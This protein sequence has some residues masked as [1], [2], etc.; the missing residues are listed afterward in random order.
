MI[1]DLRLAAFAALLIVGEAFGFACG[2]IAVAWPWVAAIAIVL[3]LAAFGWEVHGTL[4]LFMFLFGL[5]SAARIE[6]RRVEVT[7]VWCAAMGHVRRQ[8]DLRVEGEP[9][10]RYGAKGR[11]CVSFLSHLG[12]VPIK[13]VM[14][15]KKRP[16]RLPADGE[17]WRCSGALSH[18]TEQ[19]C[20]FGRRTYWI[21]EKGT[22]FPVAPPSAIKRTLKTLSNACA[23]RMGIGLGWCPEIYAANRAML[24]GRR[25]ELPSSCRRNFV[26]AGTVH[27]FAVSGLHVMFVALLLMR[28]LA[29]M[30]VPFHVCGLAASPFLVGYVLLTGCRPSAVRAAMMACIYLCAPAVGRKSDLLAAW[31]LTALAI[32][33]S[34]PSRLFDVGCTLSFAVM[35]G[36]VVWLRWIRPYLPGCVKNG[37]R[38]GI[39]ISFAAWVSG[40]PI[41]AHEFCMFT[42]AGM[43]ANVAVLPL[44][45]L[46]VAFGMVG[47]SVGFILPA[48][49]VLFNNL[50]AVSTF[51]MMK[52]S[53]IVAAV[54]F[55]S[56]QVEPWPWGG[57][58][59]WYAGISILVVL[60]VRVASR[61]AWWS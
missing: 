32:Y 9:Q 57:C 28:L 29:F 49:A 21:T 31:S 50:A 24:L 14:L 1:T 7:D 56:I 6:A 33:G 11:W 8:V 27:V 37:W 17:T 52:I 15:R 55:A 48:A 34:N 2:P 10:V 38:E 41:V 19:T 18:Q 36:I 39:G 30:Q 40:A 25:A 23:A 45:A 47:M 44:A 46:T 35:F 13:V 3:A 51:L 58:A 20:R 26:R 5:V 54:P 12:P 42:P 59:M 43:V 22:A 61:R 60:Y 4:P 53:A 16:E